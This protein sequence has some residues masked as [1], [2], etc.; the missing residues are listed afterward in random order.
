VLVKGLSRDMATNP[1]INIIYPVGGGIFIHIIRLRT[2]DFRYS[3]IEPRFTE[4][5]EML[6][7]KVQD[8]L[9]ANAFYSKDVPRNDEEFVRKLK[10]LLEE[11]T[12]DIS[13]GNLAK[14]LNQLFYGKLEIPKSKIEK[15]DYLLKRNLIYS[16]PIEGFM[17]DPYIE[18]ISCVGTN[19]IWIVHKIFGP[20]QTNVKFR[21]DAVL[22]KFLYRLTE[23]LDKPCSDTN[24]IV[25]VAM[26]DGSRL[27]VL[28][29]YDISARGSAFTIRKFTTVPISVT[30]LVKWNTISAEE[31][32]YFWLCLEHGMSAF[33]CG[34]T[35]SGKTT[36]L[37]ALAAFIR[38]DAKIFSIEDTPE[39]FVPH[40]NWQ[41]TIADGEKVTTFDLLKAS[42]RS[43]PNYV[44]VGEIRGRE[45]NVA[46]QAMQTGHPVLSTFHA[47]SIGRVIQRITGDPINVPLA[48][49]NNLNFVGIMRSVEKEGSFVRR[50]VSIHEIEGY[51][52]EEGILTREVFT[53][54]PE[55]DRHLF[56]GLYNSYILEEKVAT[57]RGL[58]EKRDIYKEMLFR[59]AVID[60]MVKRNITGY[61]DVWEVIQ[62]YMIKG[63]EGLPFF[64]EP[65][66]WE[67]I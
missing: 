16:G 18:D 42:L 34:E 21:S 7:E 65:G 5:E 29:G 20:M 4:E 22:D 31:A 56:R 11:N 61:H 39:I 33:Y 23:S 59:K 64:V 3:I 66:K 43:R 41:Q 27:N 63:K 1:K 8:V 35:A 30:Q 44:I 36:T 47:S 54:D 40:E 14:M 15:I 25:D 57:L 53:W 10:Q 58:V 24:V 26:R 9:L 51:Y 38:P 52:E 6:Y 67:T 12:M 37:K 45:G 28:F 48:F 32:A 60:E 55:T 50:F 13:S 2:G 49:I 62:K 46:F 19:P 17:R